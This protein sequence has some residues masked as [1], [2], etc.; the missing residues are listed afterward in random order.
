MQQPPIVSIIIPVFNEERYL[1]ECLKSLMALDYEKS[2]YEVI[3]VDNGS[4]D[5]SLEIAK[6]YP[7]NIFVKENV[8]VG[9]VRNYG[10]TQAKGEYIVFLDSDCVVEPNWLMYGVSRIQSTKNLVLGGQY[11]LRENPSW[12]EKYWV[13]N[14][15]RSQIYL[16]TLVGGCIFIRK[17][18]FIALQG[19]NE[20]LNSGEDSDLTYR[21]KISGS[22][23]E[24]DPKLS[25]IHLGFP[26]EILPFL[27]RQIWHS[28]DYIT[29]LQGAIKD[30]IFLLTIF[31][32]AGFFSLILHALLEASISYI[33]LAAV[34]TP[35][36]LLSY[37]RIIRSRAQLR[38]VIDFI[39]VFFVDSLY[40]IGRSCGVLLSLK[41]A[42]TDKND[43]KVNRR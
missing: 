17:S 15:S 19:F 33:S 16:T 29:N 9:A 23:V 21:L 40:L 10:V 13:L 7:I 4:T 43:L 25:V 32:M 1:A 38:S 5:K 36:I 20:K 2:H 37:K 39:C 24:I 18:T 28:S 11:L 12:L 27:K 14:N 22:D 31:Y 35:P 41:K 42:L 34:I 6:N 8:K 3:L 30:K 26:S